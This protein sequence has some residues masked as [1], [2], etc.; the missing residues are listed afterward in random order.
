MYINWSSKKGHYL[1][2]ELFIGELCFVET[3][4]SFLYPIRDAKLS[5]IE[6]NYV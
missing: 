4:K 6:Q 3:V 5:Y 1:S 2:V